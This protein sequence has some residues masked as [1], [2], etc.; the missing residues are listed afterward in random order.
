[1]KRLAYFLLFLAFSCKETKVVVPDTFLT[2][3]AN[4]EA[5]QVDND[6]LFITLKLGEDAL[7]SALQVDFT[8]TG[9]ATAEIGG[10][11]LTPGSTV[12]LSAFNEVVLKSADG[13]TR[14]YTLRKSSVF[15]EY[16]M[17]KIQEK[18]GSL[19]RNYSFYLDQYGTGTWQYI[20]CG[21]TVVTMALRWSDSTFQRAVTDARATFHPEGGWWYT[22]DIYDYLR[23]FG[24]T[25]AYSSLAASLSVEEYQAKLARILDNGNLAIVCLDMYYVRENPV[26]MERTH[27]FYTAGS[28]DWGH[29]LLV[30]GYK[31]ID[32]KMWLEVHDPYSIDKKYTS[33]QLK[34]ERRYY[35]PADI[36]TATDIWWPYAIVVPRKN[37]GTSARF[38]TEESRVPAQKGRGFF[39]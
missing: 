4:G 6:G 10:I 11:P 35:D 18:S 7:P 19:N 37:S 1:M 29:F 34:G 16:G 15:E 17:G 23:K 26:P 32:G 28:K 5:A 36:K 31:V 22:N 39:R 2:F 21:P 13:R 30:K 3:R 12:D 24:V 33:G 9:Q 27:R 25:P 20:N 8:A 38:R 14:T